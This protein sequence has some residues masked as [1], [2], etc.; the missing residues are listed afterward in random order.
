MQNPAALSP[1]VLEKIQYILKQIP[2]VAKVEL[3]KEL[4]FYHSAGCQECHKFRLQAAAWAF[5]RF[6]KNTE[7]IQALILKENLSMAEFK[8]SP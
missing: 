7:A 8:K 6:W 5:M 4:V 3:P 2:K 1:T